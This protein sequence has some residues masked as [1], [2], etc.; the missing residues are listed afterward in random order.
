MPLSRKKACFLCRES[1]ARCDRAIP[2]CSRCATRK[3]SCVYDGRDGF[4][5]SGSPYPYPCP[6]RAG[7]QSPLRQDTID[8]VALLG[9]QQEQDD[10]LAGFL[11][12]SD[13][14]Q[15]SSG[16]DQLAGGAW[17]GDALMGG[18]SSLLELD[19]IGDTF[20][21]Q[22]GTVNLGFVKPWGPVADL[23]SD[24]GIAPQD[25]WIM[26]E[27]MKTSAPVTQK[28][29]PVLTSNVNTM[30]STTHKSSSSESRTL[31]RRHVF[32]TCTMSSILLGQ[33]TS[34]P[35]MMI[36]GD[37]LPPFIHAPCRIDNELASECGERGSHQCLPRELAIC[38]SLVKMFYERTKAN[39]DFVW[40]SIYEERARLQ[41]EVYTIK[42]SILGS[43]YV[44][45]FQSTDQSHL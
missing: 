26:Q 38:A 44:Y 23:Q 43:R 29:L 15:E 36:E 11:S 16:V 39:A 4:Q 22:K 1:K 7:L 31:L 42:S 25:S 18:Q 45:S 20:A 34:Y 5:A 28:D 32:R 10:A 3:L 12:P 2:E 8:P 24:S 13:E 17:T 21:P 33:V 40:T 14:A 35:K 6:S 41:R 30:T 19:L 9:D 37:Q 27:I